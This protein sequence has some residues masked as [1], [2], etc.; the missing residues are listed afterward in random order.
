[1]ANEADVQSLEQLETFS[2]FAKRFRSQLLKEIENLRVELRKLTTWIEQD[3]LGYWQTE[4]VK[5]Q[6]RLTEAQDALTR[7]MSYVREEERKPCSVEK[8]RVKQERERCDLCEQKMKI[9]RS[10]AAFWERELTKSRA[11]LQRC[12]ELGDADLVVAIQHLDGQIERLRAYASL[13][14]PALRSGEPHAGS[15]SAAAPT[16]GSSETSSIV[17]GE[18]S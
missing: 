18:E 13:K 16:D 11:K 14:T 15:N 3:A 1:M 8:K 7:C 4:L 2:D 12:F 10:A 5:S 17:P 6:R 9:A